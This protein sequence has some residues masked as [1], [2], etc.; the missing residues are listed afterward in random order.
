ML[1]AF[2][3]IGCINDRDIDS[4]GAKACNDVLGMAV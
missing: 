2:N 3:H 4:V 1:L